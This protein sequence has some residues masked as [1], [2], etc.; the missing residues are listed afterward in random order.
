[1]NPG[2]LE[3]MDLTEAALYERIRICPIPNCRRSDRETRICYE[4]DFGAGH[5]QAMLALL[6]SYALFN[7]WPPD[8]IPSV[9][10][11]REAA[12]G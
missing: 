5:P 2:G 11:A 8:D 6:V 12:Q 9:A 10:Q 3:V 1:M 4:R 7:R